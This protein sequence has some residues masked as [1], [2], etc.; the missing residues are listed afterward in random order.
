MDDGQNSTSGY[1]RP[2]L[3]TQFK[4]GQ[5]GNPSGRPKKKGTTLV[6]ALERELSRKISV[7]EGGERQKITKLDAIVKQQTN[8]AASGDVKATALLLGILEKRESE[9]LATLPPM[10][11]A[12]RAIHA[13]HEAAD[14]NDRRILNDED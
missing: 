13:K 10:L 3:H 1:K 11:Q 12:L 9:G 6:E 8:K 4:P 2:P 7:V 14:Q 5:S